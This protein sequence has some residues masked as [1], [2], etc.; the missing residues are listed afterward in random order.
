MSGSPFDR[1]P[2]EKG[3]PTED[4]A[5]IAADRDAESEHYEADSRRAEHRRRE[6]V[7][8][9]F[10]RVATW[11]VYLLFAVFA[12]SA[13][14]VAF[15]SLAP[16]KWTWLSPIQLV[17]ARAFAFSGAVVGTIVGYLRKYLT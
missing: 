2:E 9:H 15:H 13:L 17:T 14:I 12:A 3:V 10:T 16:S 5:E 6:G 4:A 8:N 1:V 7:R 11:V